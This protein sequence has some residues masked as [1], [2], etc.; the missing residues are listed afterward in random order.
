M[1]IQQEGEKNRERL[2][3]PFEEFTKAFVDCFGIPPSKKGNNKD[4]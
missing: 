1:E 2:R 3:V 4:A